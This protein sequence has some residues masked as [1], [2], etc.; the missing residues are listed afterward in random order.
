MGIFKNLLVKRFTLNF[1][2]NFFFKGRAGQAVRGDAHKNLQAN[3]T[4]LRI[5]KAENRKILILAD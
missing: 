5:S 3:Q 4:H 2:V 1:C